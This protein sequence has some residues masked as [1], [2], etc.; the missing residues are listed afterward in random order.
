MITGGTEAHEPSRHDAWRSRGWRWR[1][2]RRSRWPSRWPWWL[3]I[4]SSSDVW[5]WPWRLWWP[6]AFRASW[7]WVSTSESSDPVCMQ[8]LITPQLPWRLSRTRSRL[9]SILSTLVL[10][11]PLLLSLLAQAGTR[12]TSV[13]RF[14]ASPGTCCLATVAAK[15]V[16][17]A[18]DCKIAFQFVGQE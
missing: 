13:P 5:W 12:D 18:K 3:R 9:Q 1:W 16:R 17:V 15:L 11:I 10:H 2:R 6:S 8:W 7:W 4:R 14:E